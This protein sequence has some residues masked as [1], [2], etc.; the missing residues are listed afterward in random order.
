[1]TLTPTELLNHAT[2][3]VFTPAVEGDEDVEALRHFR[4]Y[5]KWRSE[6]KYAVSHM[7]EVWDGTEWVYESLPSNRTDE[8]LAATRFP[9]EQAVDYAQELAHTVTVNGRTYRE[10][11]EI[12]RSDKVSK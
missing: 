3:F 12:Q 10:W 1:M 9:L 8:F 2:E 7:S 11:Y 5:V 6:G 4:I